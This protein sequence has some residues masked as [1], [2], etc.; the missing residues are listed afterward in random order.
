[1]IKAI[2][3]LH[4]TNLATVIKETGGRIF[5]VTFVKKDGSI[6]NM[7][8]RLGVTTGVK[9]TGTPVNRSN[10]VMR[11]FDMDKAAFR[12]I[13]LATTRLIKADG[14]GFVVTG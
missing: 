14:V 12:T 11:V 1:M 6:R 9:G 4:R 10:P 7:N 13:N 2:A 8:A 3:T 5:N